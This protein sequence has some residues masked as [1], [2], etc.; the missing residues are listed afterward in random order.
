MKN[1]QGFT[2][3][4]LAITVVV[5]SIL[6]SIATYSGI[7]IINSSKLTAFTTEM[8][9]MQTQVNTIY[10]KYKENNTIQIGDIIYYGE[11]KKGTQEKTILDI[12]QKVDEDSIVYQRF[13]QIK[14]KVEIE[15]SE[16]FRYWDKNLIQKLG[17]EGIEQDFFVNIEKRSVVSYEGLK[18]ENE[19]YYTLNQL[20]NDLYNVEYENPNK[21]QPTFEV[22]VIKQEESKWKVDISNI[23]YE[24]GYI[25][26]WQVKYQ[27]LGQSYW[28]TEENLSFSIN[29][30]GRYEIKIVNEKIE[31]E[32][33]VVSIGSWYDDTKKVNTPNLSEDMIPVYWDNTKEEKILTSRN[34]QQEWE[35]WYQY[36]AGDNSKDTKG[37]KWANAKTKD[38]SYWVWIPRFEYKITKPTS[39][40]AS[41]TNAGKIEVKFIPT[42]QTVADTGYTI[43][44][45]FRNDASNRFR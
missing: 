15:S 35:N 22:N 2:L 1:K 24:E 36:V 42:S 30:A 16:G 4:S 18:Y 31:S 9:I 19:I 8:K 12:G 14:S 33:Q 10:Q 17:I 37:S 32:T 38:G 26:K 27:I 21:G 34:T 25:N 40:T 20:P 29:K 45:A 5:I 3:I 39:T 13:K 6:A 28:N 41:Q 43:H 11:E 23:S 7:N 44:P